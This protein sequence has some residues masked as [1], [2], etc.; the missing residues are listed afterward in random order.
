MRARW[1]VAAATMVGIVC[2]GLRDQALAD[3]LFGHDPARIEPDWSRWGI[4]FFIN[5]KCN[6]DPTINNE[7][8]I[9]TLRNRA[10]AGVPTNAPDPPEMAVVN[11]AL[12]EQ[13]CT[14]AM[15]GFVL[16]QA[17][18]AFSYLKAHPK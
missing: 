16:A 6:F 4:A 14:T 1:V 13:L 15:R 11:S 5:R 9:A 2:S 8:V 7:L 17:A 18:E 3:A 10:L 12:P